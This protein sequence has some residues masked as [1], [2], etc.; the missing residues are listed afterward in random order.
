[1]NLPVGGT[2]ALTDS[3]LRSLEPAKHSTQK[4]FK[5]MKL[6]PK[7]NVEIKLESYQVKQEKS[8]SPPK[9]PKTKTRNKRSLQGT[10]ESKTNLE[11]KQFTS[12]DLAAL[13]APEAEQDLPIAL[14]LSAITQNT[15]QVKAKAE[16]DEINATVDLN[17]DIIRQIL[18]D[19]ARMLQRPDSE[20]R[21][22]RA[23]VIHPDKL[24]KYSLRRFV[25]K[26]V[27]LNVG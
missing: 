11:I 12:D 13:Y 18:K 25:G 24:G 23:N 4:I 6:K 15:E 20:A 22:L 16:K 7:K 2:F 9:T 3:Q 8:V 27:Q 14:Q 21:F 17:N 26:T 10:S 5:K 1:M 19:T